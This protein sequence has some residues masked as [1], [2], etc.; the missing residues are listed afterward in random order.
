GVGGQLQV[1]VGQHDADPA[2]PVRRPRPRR[3]VVLAHGL[4]G[5]AGCG[6]AASAGLMNR[7]V[8]Q[9][10]TMNVMIGMVPASSMITVGLVARLSFLDKIQ[11]NTRRRMNKMPATT[12][13]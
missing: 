4:T 2:R 5:W 6:C 1:H 8:T 11:A 13:T 7:R 10:S 9:R 3:E 12:P